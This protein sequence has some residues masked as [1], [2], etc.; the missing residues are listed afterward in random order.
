M[1]VKSENE[2]C[3]VESTFPQHVIEIEQRLRQIAGAVRRK[4]RVLLEQYG[5]TP[6]QFDALVILN[7]C[8]DLTIGDLSNRL[9]L[10]YSTTTDLVDR[11]ERAGFVA[12]QRD[13]ED[14]RVVRVKLQ[15]SGVNLYQQVINARRAYLASILESIPPSKN[16][17]I[18]SVLELLDAKMS[19]Q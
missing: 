2:V 11:L 19:E 1:P 7:R 8:G 4:G 9:F 3:L 14:R 15:S 6:P 16:E 18:L 10:A 13:S 5:I 17:E 12:R